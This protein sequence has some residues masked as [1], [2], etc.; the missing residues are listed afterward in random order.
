MERCVYAQAPLDEFTYAPEDLSKE[1]HLWVLNLKQPYYTFQNLKKLLNEEEKFKLNRYIF[2]S[3]KKRYV[4]SHGFLKKI[5]GK[6]LDI[7]P[8]DVSF[9]ISSLGKPRLDETLKP[10]NFEFSMA[11]SHELAIYALTKG[12]RVGVD[13]EYIHRKIDHMKIASK[14]F[15]KKERGILKTLPEHQ[16]K[17]AFYNCWTRKEAFI[18]TFDEKLLD[19][20]EFEVTIIPGEA[21][22][23][24]NIEGYP[25]E[26]THWYMISFSPAESYV[27]A[28]VGEGRNWKP[29]FHYAYISHAQ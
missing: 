3:D 21:P 11:H 24:I 4:V 23:I 16:R 12:R 8:N 10:I 20:Q 25:M 15:T 13:I 1:I 14:F 29:R 22:Q 18:K 9:R 26:S 2:N 17:K 5:I 19:F 7:N 28:L 6:Y 27:G